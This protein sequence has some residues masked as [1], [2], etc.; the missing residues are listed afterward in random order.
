MGFFSTEADDSSEPEETDK[1][2]D[3]M[4]EREEPFSVFFFCAGGRGY[5]V[6]A[7]M[8]SKCQRGSF[9]LQIG[10]FGQ[11]ILVSVSF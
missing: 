3:G 11:F 6:S 5:I 1:E 9:V 2:L 4:D 8:Q 10:D 7:K